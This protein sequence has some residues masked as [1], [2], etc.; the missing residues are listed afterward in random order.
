[1]VRLWIHP[2][3]RVTET[4]Y[5]SEDAASV[6]RVNEKL[7]ARWPEATAV[8]FSNDDYEAAIP[9]TLAGA[10]E[11][12][13]TWRWRDGRL[14]ANPTI[15]VQTPLAERVAALEARLR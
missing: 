11:R 12:P 1:M 10:V 13:E 15:P 6:A 14:A 7:Q 4:V 9:R 8:D 5:V 3:G 2:D